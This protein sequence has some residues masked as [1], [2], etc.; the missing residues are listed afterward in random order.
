MFILI[1]NFPK[2][3]QTPHTCRYS[4]IPLYI[5]THML[6]NF[7][8]IISLHCQPSKYDIAQFVVI[9]MLMFGFCLL[10]YIIITIYIYT[11]PHLLFQNMLHLQLYS[12][13]SDV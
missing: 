8:I 6:M 9:N 5:H 10:T 7:M 12:L 4:Y 3:L 2:A 11:S 13:H 1:A